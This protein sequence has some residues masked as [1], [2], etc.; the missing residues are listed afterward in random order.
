MSPSPPPP[1]VTTAAV[2]GATNHNGGAG[3]HAILGGS[4]PSSLLLSARLSQTN[5]Q[6]VA[7]ALAARAATISTH[8]PIPPTSRQ[9]TSADEK[10]GGRMEVDGL[11][12]RAGCFTSQNDGR[13]DEE[14]P[15]RSE[16]FNGK[17]DNVLLY[18]TTHPA[19]A[20]ASPR[21][22]SNRHVRNE[23]H[24]ASTV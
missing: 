9:R 16:L 8:S 2:V 5:P 4:S 18:S 3:I 15:T 1:P 12:Q 14:Q 20:S 23:D 22:L 11:S 10:G 7:A 17:P 24:R 6:V 13:M 21:D 19:S